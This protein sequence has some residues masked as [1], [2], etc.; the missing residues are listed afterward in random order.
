MI[1]FENFFSL[2]YQS[3]RL[4]QQ[5]F[6]SSRIALYKAAHVYFT[7]SCPDELFNELC[8][9][10]CAKYI[11]TLKEINIAF[12]PY[13]SQVYSLDCHE[14]FQCYYSP[15]KQSAR[16]ATLE[17]LAEQVATLC[18]TLGEYPN[19]RYR[20]DF[21]RNVELAQLIQQKLQAHK[22]DEPTMGEVSLLYIVYD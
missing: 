9:S 3:I 13:E 20:M 15:T 18:A 17:R 2:N 8:K 21:D 22:A 19:I 12:L 10:P 4:L 5:D 1:N 14:S 16:T 11:K 7:E 6:L